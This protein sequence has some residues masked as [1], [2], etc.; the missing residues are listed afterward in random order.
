M[1]FLFDRI[2]CGAH[3]LFVEHYG[4]YLKPLDRVINPDE[5]SDIIYEQLNQDN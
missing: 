1:F 5:A 2:L 4:S 3:R